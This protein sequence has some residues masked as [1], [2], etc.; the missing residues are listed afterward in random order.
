MKRQIDSS[1][2][3]LE[4]M[5]AKLEK[6]MLV[7]A[8]VATEDVKQIKNVREGVFDSKQATC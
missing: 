4:N 5:N 6:L 3:A 1:G 8:S 2:A 7:V